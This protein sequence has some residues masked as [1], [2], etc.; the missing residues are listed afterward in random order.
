MRD[1]WA[2]SAPMGRAG[3]GGGVS[4]KIVPF[5]LNVEEGVVYIKFNQGR[6]VRG[7]VRYNCS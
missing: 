3:G 4:G 6:G 2:G 1:A 5:V 7:R